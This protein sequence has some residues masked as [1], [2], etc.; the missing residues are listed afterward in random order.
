MKKILALMMSLLMICGLAACGEQQTDSEQTP[1]EIVKAAS[2]KLNNA[3]GVAYG[4]EMG[5]KMSDPESDENSIDMAMTGDIEM[6]M[7]AE[8][9]YKL[10]YHMVTDMSMMD[11]AAGKVEMDMYY[12]DGYMYYDMSQLGITY[13]IAMD[14]TE[15]MEYV[16]SA[17]FD[18]IEEGMVKEQSIKA[19][20]TG[21]IVKMTLDGTKMT[22]MVKS[23]SEEFATMGE[24]DAMTIGDIPYTVCL[25]EDGNITD[26]DMVVDFA[27]DVEGMTMN[28][29]MDTKMTVKQVGG[30]TV[31][32]PENLADYQELSLDVED[33]AA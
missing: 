30:V 28:M 3:D 31:E 17:S 21:Q 23:M 15:A 8:N 18:D 9:N 5:L 20:G 22:D 11:E 32:L 4:L 12:A 13:K 1:Y 33:M 29:S 26:I 19:D 7:V 16:N 2:E 24:D 10:A 27:M 25:D 6:E 14:M